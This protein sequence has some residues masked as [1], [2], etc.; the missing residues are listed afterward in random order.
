MRMKSVFSIVFLFALVASAQ[1]GG[2]SERVREA[3]RGSQAVW[4]SWIVPVIDGHEYT[5]C[6]SRDWKR[7]PC[8]LEA[9]NQSWGSSDQDPRK[10]PNLNV[11]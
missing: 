9:K 11:L 7:A 10:D 2:L 6:W 4:V 3:G 5:C 8:K 1:T